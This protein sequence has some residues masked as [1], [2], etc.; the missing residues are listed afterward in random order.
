MEILKNK[1]AILDCIKSEKA[2]SQLYEISDS[3]IAVDY[4]EFNEK[5]NQ[6]DITARKNM[7]K[8]IN[9]DKN[10]VTKVFST[11]FER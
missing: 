3:L 4:S 5:Y 6:R 10:K 1:K 2:F 7:R 9:S 8:L 11:L